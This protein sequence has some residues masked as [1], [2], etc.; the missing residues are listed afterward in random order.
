MKGGFATS[1][2]TSIDKEMDYMDVEDV[3]RVLGNG[4]AWY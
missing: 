2:G 4:L 3:A 1:R